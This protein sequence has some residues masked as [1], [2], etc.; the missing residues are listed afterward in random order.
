ML[1]AKLYAAGRLAYS[2]GLIFAPVRLASGWIG[3]QEAASTGA[4]IGLRGLAAR[5]AALSFGILVAEARGRSSRPWLA[6]CA[7]GD[8]AD[9][10]ATLAAPASD[11]PSHSRTG[12]VA[13]AGGSALIG[14]VLAVRG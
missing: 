6:L 14:A 4:Q 12:T 3:R 8:L 10:T 5:D 13:L 9:L 2:A 11:L 7:L 1:A